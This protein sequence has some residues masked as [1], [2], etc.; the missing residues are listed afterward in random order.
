M[1]LWQAVHFSLPFLFTSSSV[2]SAAALLDL[3]KLNPHEQKIVERFGAVG[4]VAE[5]GLMFAIEREASVVEQVG[6]PLRQGW[7]GRLWQTS[8]LLN[9]LSL[10]TFLLPK[11]S[12]IRR[13]LSSLF[14][15][16]GALCLH[17]AVIETG[18]ASVR[19]PRA[20]FLQQRAGHGAAEV[21]GT[22]AVTGPDCERA[23][24]AF[25]TRKI[26]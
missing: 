18:H 8:K 22:A 19:D 5:L 17:F 16:A 20:T 9:L 1:P 15:C 26:N 23:F 21:T 13:V 24:A 11:Q 3:F 4:K 10:L 7:C 25:S 6:R 14:T 12:R 2:A